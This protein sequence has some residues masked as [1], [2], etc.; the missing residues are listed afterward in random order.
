MAV[1]FSRR[2]VFLT[3][4][5]AVWA[6]L[7]IAP[8][9]AH[10][11][12]P[13]LQAQIGLPSVPVPALTPC[14]SSAFATDSH[15]QPSGAWAGCRPGWHCFRSVPQCLLLYAVKVVCRVVAGARAVENRIL[16]HT[17]RSTIGARLCTQ[18]RGPIGAVVIE[19]PIGNAP[20]T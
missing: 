16:T 13:L 17:I 15:S 2:G 1:F 18:S 4:Q 14:L 3:A 11:A 5:T 6:A 8:E 9:T 7:A 19:P 20:V 12:I 10:L